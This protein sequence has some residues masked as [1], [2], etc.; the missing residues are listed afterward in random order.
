MENPVILHVFL[1]S[2]DFFSRSTFLECYFGN[3]IRVSNSLDPVQV[4]HFVW[5]GLGPN[6]LQRFSADDTCRQRVKHDHDN[7]IAQCIGVAPIMQEHIKNTCSNIQGRSPN[8][9]K[10]IFH[11]IRNCS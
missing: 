8:V 6:C 10:V 3:T 7:I 4:R 11:T 1:S 2:A 5:P 9:V